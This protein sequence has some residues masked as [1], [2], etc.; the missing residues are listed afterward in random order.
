M[1]RSQE[2]ALGDVAA[3]GPPRRLTLERA[4]GLGDEGAPSR[5]LPSAAAEFDEQLRAAVVGT[6]SHAD[7]DP[8]LEEAVGSAF[9]W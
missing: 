7:L 6:R 1:K 5:M 9:D 2:R 4:L 8:G 3:I